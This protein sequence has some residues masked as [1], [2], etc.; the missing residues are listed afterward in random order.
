MATI[1]ATSDAGTLSS[2]I[3][4]RL[5]VPTSS[6]RAM[7]TDTWNSDRRNR[8]GSGRSGDAASAKGR[9][10]SPQV[11]QAPANFWLRRLMA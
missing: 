1:T 7:P 10:R 2:T 3:I 5:R 9:K 4:T 6:T 11:V 8:R